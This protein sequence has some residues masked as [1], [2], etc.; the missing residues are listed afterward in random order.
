MEG[1]FA[2]AHLIRHQR[3]VLVELGW[4]VRVGESNS[5]IKR[6]LVLFPICYSITNWGKKTWSLKG[7]KSHSKK[8]SP[9]STDMA[10]THNLIRFYSVKKISPLSSRLN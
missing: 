7:E 5:Y 9:S 3:W 1:Y 4:A 6:V 2:L 10:D 8:A